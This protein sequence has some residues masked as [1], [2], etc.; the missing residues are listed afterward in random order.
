MT[1]VLVGTPNKRAVRLLWRTVIAILASLAPAVAE[2]LSRSVLVLDQSIPYNTWFTELMAADSIPVRVD[3]VHLQQV[4]LNLAINGIDAM[5][6][7]SGPRS[8]ALRIARTGAGE[9]TVSVSDDGPGIPQEKLNSIFET[10]YT[11]KQHGSGLGLSIA[12]TIVEIY[13]GKLWAENR[14]DGGAMFSFTLPLAAGDR[15]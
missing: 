1:A 4:I 12:R 7:V 5:Q 11:T 9:A 10:F 3:P 14:R 6:E 15:A 8:I 13:G 2:P